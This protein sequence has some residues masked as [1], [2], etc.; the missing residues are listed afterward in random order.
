MQ[1]IKPNLNVAAPLNSTVLRATSSQLNALPKDFEQTLR[2]TS[3]PP[4]RKSA[5]HRSDGVRSG[6][7]L[8]DSGNKAP[9]TVPVAVSAIGSA[10]AAAIGSSAA[11][12]IPAAVPAAVTLT[13]E[14]DD[15]PTSASV[16]TTAPAAPSSAAKRVDTPVS[17]DLNSLASIGAGA[18]TGPAVTPAKSGA[19]IGNNTPPPVSAVPVT[20]QAAVPS[21]IESAGATDTKAGGKNVSGTGNAAANPANPANASNASA[22]TSDSSAS[23]AAAPADADATSQT[24]LAATMAAAAAGVLAPAASSAAAANTLAAPAT[25]VGPAG[26][27]NIAAPVAMGAARPAS[28]A[29]AGSAAQAVIAAADVSAADK[30]LHEPSADSGT[31]TLSN[32]GTA[33]FAQLVSNSSSADAAPASLKVAAGVDTPE[34][35]QGV[36][37]QVQLMMDNSLNTAKLQVTPAS[38][39]PIEVRIAIQNGHAQVWMTSHSAVTRDALESSTPQLKEMLGSQGF[40]QVSVDISQRSFQERTPQPHSYD[41]QP[42]TREDS[43]ASVQSVAAS[44]VRGGSGVVDAYA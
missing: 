33:G 34:F 36:G 24:I 40:S 13:S 16:A 26:N 31:A 10:K 20:A 12:A 6:K 28:A 35:A 27:V 1:A 42:A 7:H 38:L 22:A 11:S 5:S 21:A 8:P 3:D 41:W 4:V 9:A 29:A 39:G 19:A 44:A 18:S 37:S 43:A 30:H 23:G 14:A 32:Q 25:G 17:A 15:S 2:D